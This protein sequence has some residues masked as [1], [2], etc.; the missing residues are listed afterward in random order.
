MNAAEAPRPFRPKVLSSRHS[1]ERGRRLAR[2]VYRGA[3]LSAVAVLGVLGY[4][5]A[6][7]SSLLTVTEVILEE[8]QR[9]PLEELLRLAQVPRA[10]NI[11]RVDTQGIADRVASH[12][13]VED[14]S[15]MRRFPHTLIVRVKE[16]LPIAVLQGNQAVLLD[17]YGVILGP[18][19]AGVRGDFV[20]LSGGR[21]GVL[22]PGAIVGQPLRAA[23]EVLHTLRRERAFGGMRI[24]R[25]HV[26]DEG[27]IE[28]HLQ[29]NSLVVVLRG[30]DLASQIA[31]F[32]AVAASFGPALPSRLRIDVSFAGQAV[33]RSL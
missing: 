9:A 12:A 13:W 31:R 24:S 1:V 25:L 7:S 27:T 3:M 6:V 15:V 14:A 21:E 11:L 8:A 16:R 30:E 26:V 28:V 4:Q 22:R 23:L 2:A 10:T 17:R 29:P 18:A 5:V 32:D 33:V 19:D 20:A